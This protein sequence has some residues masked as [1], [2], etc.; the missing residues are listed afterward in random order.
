MFLQPDVGAAGQFECGWSTRGTF[1]PLH[2]GCLH[3]NVVT[4]EGLMRQRRIEAARR[5]TVLCEGSALFGLA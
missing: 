2:G 3:A 1:W 4:A 5:Q